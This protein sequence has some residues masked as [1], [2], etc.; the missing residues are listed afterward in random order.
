M[1]ENVVNFNIADLT[2]SLTLKIEITGVRK[3]RIRLWV[4]C[5]LIKLAAH[6]MRMGIEIKKA[7][8]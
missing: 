1:T 6:I 7:E 5:Q 3:Y 4:G 8:D 2:P